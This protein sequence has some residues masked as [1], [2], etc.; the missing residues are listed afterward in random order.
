MIHSKKLEVDDAWGTVI[1]RGEVNA[2]KDEFVMTCKKLT[3]YYEKSPEKEGAAEAN[4]ADVQTR[5]EKLVASGDVNIKRAQGGTATADE[6]VY[7][8]EDEKVVLTGRPVVKQ[9]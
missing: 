4:A 1:L 5:I 3:V 7:Y 8:Q 2:K 9:G 6:A